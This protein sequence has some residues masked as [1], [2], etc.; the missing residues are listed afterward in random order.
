[1]LMD[2]GTRRVLVSNFDDRPGLNLLY[3]FLV[4]AHHIGLTSLLVF[5]Q[6]QETCERAMKAIGPFD[7]FVDLTM[8]NTRFFGKAIIHKYY[9]VFNL[10]RLG[11]DTV[12]MDFDV[13]FLRH[14]LLHW[15]R[16][17]DRGPAASSLRTHAATADVDLYAISDCD[18]MNRFAFK[19][20]LFNAS[21]QVLNEL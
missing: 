3:N 19:P 14:P 8:K 5:G 2:D 10:T 13:V 16:L 21:E 12:F 18:K 15:P 1:M 4:G 17:W 7:C 20:E 11:F 6:S 9:L